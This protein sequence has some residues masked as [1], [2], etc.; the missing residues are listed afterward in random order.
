MEQQNRS[1]LRLAW[2][3]A[4]RLLSP[5]T[6]HSI[7][8]FACYRKAQGSDA[9]HNAS[10]REHDSRRILIARHPSRL[11]DYNEHFLQ[12]VRS[13]RPEIASRMQLCRLPAWGIDWDR[14]ALFIPW[15]Q[16]PLKENYPLDYYFAMRMQRK[17]RARGIPIVHAVEGLSNS[18][19]SVALPIMGKLG[20]RTA[21]IVRITD[22]KAFLSSFGG[23]T[24]PF[25]IREDRVHSGSCFLIRQEE[26]VHQVDW[27]A[28]S[29][30]V[31]VE[32]IDV[33]SE[34]GFYRKYRYVLF[35]DEGVPPHLIISQNWIVH[36]DLRVFNAHTRQEEAD[37]V[38]N[39]DPNHEILNRARKALGLDFVAFDYSYDKS[40]KLI[41][42]E[43]NPFPVL[44]AGFN[45]S[46]LYDY[47]SETMERLYEGILAYY[48]RT[49]GF[50]SGAVNKG[51]GTGQDLDD[52]R[53][54]GGDYKK[55]FEARGHDYNKAKTICLNARQAEINALLDRAVFTTGQVVMDTPAGGGVVADGVHARTR[56]GVEIICVEPSP[57]FA[58]AISGAYRVLHHEMPAVALPDASVD[59]ILSLAGLHHVAD[60]APVYAEWNRLL[61]PGGQLV[62]ADVAS[63]TPTG[64]F[65]NEFIDRFTQGGH[66][67]VFI[68]ENEFE[69]GLG[70]AGLMASNCRLED[71][72]WRFPDR[73]TMALFCWTLFSAK[74]T[75]PDRVAESLIDYVGLA[76][77]EGGGIQINWQLRYA[78]ATKPR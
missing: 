34:D 1:W 72:P 69:D 31:A 29:H 27:Q 56:G 46:Q 15:L 32:Y 43:P 2:R 9:P 19:K 57:Q 61:K 77:T 78:T 40:G 33:Q 75:T 73:E 22:R 68:E 11:T 48:V 51:G 50:V 5:K 30:P 49:A 58:E 74:K 65:L 7:Q 25:F 63:G 47:Q 24:P 59:V 12:W 18:I 67:G 6:R 45:D 66:Q 62:V 44:W 37:Y 54:T 41:V 16:D 10:L 71:V 52:S 55:T 39:P 42:W 76:N 13:S 3:L 38:E 35:G 23:L 8:T 26:D 36:A 21:R 64:A 28:Y 4:W 70:E 20:I 60:R 14:V 53:Q 17:C